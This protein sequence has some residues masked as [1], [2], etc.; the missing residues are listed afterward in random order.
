MR[1]F[2]NRCFSFRSWAGCWLVG[3]AMA[4]GHAAQAQ[5]YPWQALPTAPQNGQ[6]QDD[7]FFLNPQLGWAVNGSGHIS[8]TANGGTTWTRQLTQP[9]TYF[10]CIGFANSQ[11]GFAGNIG[12][13]YFPGVTDTN[14]LYR[15]QD[16]GLTWQPVPASAISGPVPTGLCALQ[17]VTPQVIYAAGRVGGPAHL[18][19]SSDGG[20]TWIS[21]SLSPQIGMITDV[22]FMAADTGF[23]FGGSSSN[24][25][26]SATKV[27][28]TTDGG[29]TF[30]S[31]YQ[32]ARPFEMVWKASFVDRRVG[33]CTVLSYNTG[34]TARYVAKTTDGGLTWTELPFAAN[35]CKEFG[36]GFA[37]E[38]IGWVGTDVGTGSETQDGGLT[39]QPGT[40]G[41]FV[42]KVRLLRNASG[43]LTGYA[44]GLNVR[45]LSTILAVAPAVAPAPF[46]LAAFPNPATRQLTLRYELPRRQA[47]RLVMSDLLGREIAVL[48]DYTQDAGPHELTY[49]L[50]AALSANMV[51][52]TLVTAQ[53]RA[54]LPVSVQP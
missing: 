43:R 16:G 4:F 18:M 27:L 53:G 39:W 7:V 25:A 5:S 33:Y 29:L 42:N 19:K 51:Q 34:T 21:R 52:L 35:G 2:V 17:V 3:L 23:V 46:A 50:P 40:L 49:A 9:G 30:R 6:K 37:T 13:N 24:I 14:P 31:V 41:Q 20:L 10:R 12:T 11:L 38:Q 22:H 54:T 48:A 47:V 44:I 32:S 15:T 28:Y 8:Q 36:I 1:F 45:K 26:A